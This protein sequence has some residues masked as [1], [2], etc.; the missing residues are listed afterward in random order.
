MRRWDIVLRITTRRGICDSSP[1]AS[2]MIQVGFAAG[3]WGRRSLPRFV[4]RE[5]KTAYPGGCGPPSRIDAP[6]RRTQLRAAAAVVTPGGKA[7]L[8]AS[9]AGAG[10]GQD[11]ACYSHR[12]SL[13]ARRRGDRSLPQEIPGP[14]HVHQN[15]GG[16]GRWP[17][18]GRRRWSP[19]GPVHCWGD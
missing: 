14:N 19:A 2:K 5:R 10:S 4:G 18:A 11:P 13:P 9:L 3:P 8:L 16:P 7:R 6:P 17:P 15:K 1:E 12:K